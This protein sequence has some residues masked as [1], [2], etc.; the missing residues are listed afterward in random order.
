MAE[1][2]EIPVPLRAVPV[3]ENTPVP[4]LAAMS[5]LLP[6]DRVTWIVQSPPVGPLSFTAQPLGRLTGAPDTP[7][8][9]AEGIVRLIHAIV[10]LEPV[11]EIVS[12]WVKAPGAT[13]IG[14]GS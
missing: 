3:T 7:E 13:V 5:G 1:F 11:F 12:C 2:H 9:F 10:V 14:E 6:L 4:P 8:K